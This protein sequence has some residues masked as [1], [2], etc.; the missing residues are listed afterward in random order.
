[1]AERPLTSTR[2][3][4]EDA[5]VD[6]G[7][8]RR[9]LDE[10]EQQTALLRGQ[11]RELVRQ[12]EERLAFV[13]RATHEALWDWDFA[14]NIVWWSEGLR[15]QFGHPINE[16]TARLDWWRQSI[17]PDDRDRVWSTFENRGWTFGPTSIVSDGPTAPTRTS[18][19]VAM[20]STTPA[21]SRSA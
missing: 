9:A 12:S 16:D 21:G 2:R 18:T 4:L 11:L 6:S 10:Q 20:S 1:M 3:D 13:G 17:H 7:R 8:L 5:N 15:T 19:R 14:T